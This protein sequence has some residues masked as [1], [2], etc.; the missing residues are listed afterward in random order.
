MHHNVR[1]ALR[2]SRTARGMTI[3]K[4]H[5]SK[6]PERKGKLRASAPSFYQAHC[7]EDDVRRDVFAMPS[8]VH[9]LVHNIRLT[10]P[11]DGPTG[12]TK[13]THVNPSRSE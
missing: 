6:S 3:S 2:V 9:N 8:L 5:A 4:R 11:R 13:N 1:A 7:G 10:R 12:P